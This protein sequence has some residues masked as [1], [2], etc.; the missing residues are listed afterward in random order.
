MDLRVGYSA[1]KDGAVRVTRDGRRV[2]VIGGADA[3]RLLGRLE[4][5]ADEVERQGLLARA[6]GNHKRG[7]ER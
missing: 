5:A 2:S 6:T 7:N 3:R 4:R 1:T